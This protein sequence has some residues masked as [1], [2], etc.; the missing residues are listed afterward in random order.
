MDLF[1]DNT[2]MNFSLLRLLGVNGG[3]FV[4]TVKRLSVSWANLNLLRKVGLSCVLP[5]YHLQ[6]S[7]PL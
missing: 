3:Q 4:R 6:L 7:F 2:A 5:N 1:S